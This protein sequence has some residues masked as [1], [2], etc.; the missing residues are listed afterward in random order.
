M[1]Y[2]LIFQGI[3][4]NTIIKDTNNNHFKLKASIPKTK[5]NK[6]THIPTIVGSIYLS[7]YLSINIIPL[8]IQMD[9]I[10]REYL[11][12][13]NIRLILQA[14]TI[15]HI[16]GKILHL[17][18]CL[19]CLWLLIRLFRILDSNRQSLCHLVGLLVVALFTSC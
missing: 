16:L 4:I 8:L 7:K 18:R 11:S 6:A 2:L 13:S 15:H 10:S 5:A 17:L 12:L 9:M 14:Q 19:W 3:Y 1:I